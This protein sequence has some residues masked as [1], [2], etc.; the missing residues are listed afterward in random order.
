MHLQVKA[1][2]P[3][4]QRDGGHAGHHHPQRALDGPGGALAD[5]ALPGQPDRAQDDHRRQE[6]EVDGVAQR[7][8][9]PVH[10]VLQPGQDVVARRRLVDRDRHPVHRLRRVEDHPGDVVADQRRHIGALQAV[11][12]PELPGHPVVVVQRLPARRRAR[13]LDHRVDAA[14]G[15]FRLRQRGVA[16]VVQVTDDPARTLVAQPDQAADVPDTRHL[17]DPAGL[18]GCG[19]GEADG[20]AGLDG[21]G[22]GRVG[23]VNHM[24]RGEGR[25]GE[26]EQCHCEQQH[27][28]DPA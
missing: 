28:D 14:G 18:S 5:Q 6:G 4:D 8:D 26:C 2:G 19:R 10:R 22:A 1:A 16:D 9:Q 11:R 25:G 13:R 20:R 24:G 12:G 27:P 7:A 23:R 15:L 21:G 3:P 17:T